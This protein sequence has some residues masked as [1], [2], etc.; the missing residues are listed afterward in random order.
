MESARFAAALGVTECTLCRFAPPEF[1]RAVAFAEYD[2]EVREMLHLLKFHGMRSVAQH[3]LGRW[4]ADAILQLEPSAA[5]D[6]I[7]VPVPLFAARE[8]S[9]GFNQATLLADS[10]LQ[11]LRHLRPSWKLHLQPFA[12][13]RVKDTRALFALQPHQRRHSLRGAFRIGD[14]ALVRGREVLLIDDILT[15]GATAR[16][17]ARVLLRA[18]ATNIWVATVARAQPESVRLTFA[19]ESAVARWD[20]P[21]MPS[22][23][24]AGTQD[25]C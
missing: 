6:L 11:R 21:T 18:G 2:A 9:R 14:A 8:R 23:P 17:C 22:A 10:A 24:S 7:V 20:A 1:T 12:L 3:V 16:E 13:L 25:H 5:R 15:T 19:P 4:L